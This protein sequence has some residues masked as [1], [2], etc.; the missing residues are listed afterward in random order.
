MSEIKI[1]G[2]KESTKNRLKE[3]AKERYYS[4]LNQYLIDLLESVVE[5]EGLSPFEQQVAKRNEIIAVQLEKSHEV[6]ARAIDF[7]ERKYHE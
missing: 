3:I 5:N 6:M 4:S 7:L 2:L 1:R